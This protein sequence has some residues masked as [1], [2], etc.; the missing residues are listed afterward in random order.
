MTANVSQA[1]G[2]QGIPAGGMEMIRDN[3]VLVCLVEQLEHER[4]LEADDG[5]EC[6]R[7][8]HVARCF[9]CPED[10]LR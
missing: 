10:S 4:A 2:S 6:K 1:A 3:Q 9:R 5:H 8:L 7:D